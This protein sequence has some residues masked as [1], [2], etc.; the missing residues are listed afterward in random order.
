[1]VKKTEMGEGEGEKN[2][3][4]RSTINDQRAVVKTEKRREKSVKRENKRPKKKERKRRGGDKN[5][6]IDG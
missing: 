1:M 5:G 4:I 3:G 2:S 6:W